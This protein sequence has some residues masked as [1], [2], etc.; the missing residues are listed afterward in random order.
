MLVVTLQVPFL[1]GAPVPAPSNLDIRRSNPPLQAS[2]LAISYMHLT[3]YAVNKHNENFVAN[4]GMDEDDED[5]SK[6]GLEQL[7]EHMTEE[8]HDWPAIWSSIQ[9]L[10]MKSLISVQPLLKNNYRSVMPLDN[11]GFSCFEILGYDVMLD[12]GAWEVK[13]GGDGTGHR[14]WVSPR[15]EGG[16][17][18]AD[19]SPGAE[20]TL[21]AGGSPGAEGTGMAG[22]SPCPVGTG[23]GRHVGG[24]SRPEGPLWVQLPL[25]QH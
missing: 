1:A 11:D 13:G 4:Q 24:P 18:M 10:I 25:V 7:A 22:G 16:T 14:A 23:M 3:N 20:G 2:N 5:A 15:A 19:V 21:M 17:G 12:T 6:L 9:Q 8:G